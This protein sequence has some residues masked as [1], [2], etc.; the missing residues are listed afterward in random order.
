MVI[1]LHHLS[2]S[3][4]SSSRLCGNDSNI[5]IPFFSCRYVEMSLIPMVIMEHDRLHSPLWINCVIDVTSCLNSSISTRTKK[6]L[7]QIKSKK[8]RKSPFSPP[9]I[10]LFH[11]SSV[12]RFLCSCSTVPLCTFLLIQ[13]NCITY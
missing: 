11:Y 10:P 3:S 2:S 13:Y 12:P 1:C 4:S 9:S 5:P 7:M 8:E 6:E